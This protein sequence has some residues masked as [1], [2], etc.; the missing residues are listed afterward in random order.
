MYCT[1]SY[2]ATTRQGYPI[3]RIKKWKNS[4]DS[5][6]TPSFVF[7]TFCFCRRR[8]IKIT[9][10]P[11]FSLKYTRLSLS[12]KTLPKNKP[13]KFILTI[14]SFVPLLSCC[15]TLNQPHKESNLQRFFQTLVLYQ[16]Y[17]FC[18]SFLPSLLNFSRD[19]LA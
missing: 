13:T 1:D 3:P 6:F 11:G 7:D 4:F 5:T 9:L 8:Y 10:T 14:H 19:N 15:L 18:H 12:L 2:V 16:Q 17:L